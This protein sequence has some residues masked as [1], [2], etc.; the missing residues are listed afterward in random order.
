MHWA[1]DVW[2]YALS[3]ACAGL[4]G[5][6]RRPAGLY[7][8][9][10]FAAGVLAN[11]LVDQVCLHV[12]PVDVAGTSPPDPRNVILRLEITA[13]AQ[14][15]ACLLATYVVSRWWRRF[16]SELGEIERPRAPGGTRR[17]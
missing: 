10:A 7:V 9:I 1:W 14:L 12:I 4:W 5:A 11:L 15:P 2:P 16:P 17:E 13:A 6:L 8:L 3:V